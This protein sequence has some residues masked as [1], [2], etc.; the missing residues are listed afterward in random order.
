VTSP[1]Q[2][3]QSLVG[4]VFGGQFRLE[5]LLGRG[6]M[7]EVYLAEQLELGRHVVLKLLLY[8]Q[9]WSSPELEERFR[10]EARILAR[11]NHPNIV[12][13]YSFGR[14]EDGI[15][16]LAME[17]IEGRTLTNTIAERGAL[18][19]SLTLTILDQLASALVEAHGHGIVHRDLKPDNVMIV[20][21]YGRPAFVKVLDF[22]IAK[23]TRAHDPRLTRSG[24]ILGTPQYMAPE[25]LK[26]QVID[27]RT[28]IYALGLIGYELLTGEVPFHGDNTMDLM[29]RVLNEEAVPP[30][31]KPHGQHVSAATE[32]V[33]C[34]CI[35]K[36]PEQRF[37]SAAELRDALAAVPRAP[38]RETRSERPMIELRLETEADSELRV[39]SRRGRAA[40]IG[41]GV[42]LVLIAAAGGLVWSAYAGRSISLPVPAHTRDIEARGPLSVRE[43]VQGIPFPDG[44]DYDEFEPQFVEARVA[45][46]SS[47]VLAFY[48]LHIAE[49][50][51]A[52]QDLGGEL[53]VSNPNAPIASVMVWDDEQGSRLFIKRRGPRDSH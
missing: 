23:L 17:Y 27:E 22:G 49:K 10:R 2:P 40:A 1:S 39:R 48:R 52:F 19:E 20:E 41:A 5:A 51:G 18:S 15:S 11:L 16:Y 45:A 8:S 38:G 42:S 50:W 7:G 28:D 35:A 44:T 43:W 53:V 31:R 12:Q 29:L 26:E 24:A 3:A 47:A 32:A 46:D 21:R 30:S 6:G 34:R 14:S 33:I 13:L 37:Q 4:R 36:E 25:Q 9:L